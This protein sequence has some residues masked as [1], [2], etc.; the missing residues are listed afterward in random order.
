[1]GL[2]KLEELKDDTWAC[3][4]CSMCR[5][6]ESKGIAKTHA[7]VGVCPVYDVLRFDHY[8]SR[9]RNTIAKYLL[10]EVLTYN[11]SLAEDI[12]FRCLGCKACEE[13]CTPTLLPG[14]KP[15]ENMKIVR[16][17]RHDCFNR[18]L[19]PEK[20]KTTLQK[21]TEPGIGNPFGLDKDSRRDW[22]EELNLPK[23]ANILYYAG[24]AAS[25]QNQ[26]TPEALIKLMQA[27][28]EDHESDDI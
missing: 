18:G 22:S 4:C 27:A 5:D 8:T 10:G 6:T 23:K 3:G 9:G 12:I 14:M 11:E 21:I 15:I 20:L 2:M 24:C 1:M 16:A 7:W 19:M 28:G 25:Y 13:I 17:M 26:N